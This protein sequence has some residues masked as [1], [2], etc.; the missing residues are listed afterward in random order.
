RRRRRG[1]QP[2]R[3]VTPPARVGCLTSHHL[4]SSGAVRA[5]L[6]LVHGTTVAREHPFAGF[7]DNPGSSLGPSVSDCSVAFD[8]HAGEISSSPDTSQC[9]SSRTSPK[10]STARASVT[11][12]G[13]SRSKVGQRVYGYHGPGQDGPRPAQYYASPPTPAYQ[14]PSDKPPLP[15]G[16]TP[17]FDQQHQRWYYVEEATGQTQWEAPGYDPPPPPR[18]SRPGDDRRAYGQGYEVNK[19]KTGGG[20]GGVLLGATGGLAVGAIGGALLHHALSDEERRHQPAPPP[21]LSATD[22]DS[23]SVSSSDREAVQEARAR[24]EDALAAAA[25]L[26]ANSSEEEELEEAR[27][28]YYEEYEDTYGG[29]DDY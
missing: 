22:S 5:S 29:D 16:W 19:Q 28:E 21:M 18:G 23:S 24:Y 3:L 26:D 6:V 9:P 14:P 11:A 13:T 20:K 7:L 17:L 2:G 27:E 25:D 10:D 1:P 8:Q 12:K 4:T 15:R